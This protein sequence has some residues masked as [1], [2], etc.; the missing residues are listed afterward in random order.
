VKNVSGAYSF[1]CST[2][3]KFTN[4]EATNSDAAYTWLVNPATPCLSEL[5]GARMIVLSEPG[6]HSADPENH[7]GLYVGTRESS[8][9][10]TVAGV[11]GTRRT[12]VVSADN[13]LPPPKNTVQVLYTFVTGG[14]TYFAEYDRY[15]GD[16]DLTSA[17]DQMV[18]GSFRFSA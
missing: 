11:S 5:Y 17:F 4:C 16:T 18:V 8:Q 6:D 9:P 10:V 13:P 15:P 1:Q 3:W 12:Y 14:R 2:S 7:Q